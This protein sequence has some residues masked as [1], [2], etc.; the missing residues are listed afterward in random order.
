MGSHRLGL[1]PDS[2]IQL[3]NFVF[4]LTG[5]RKY[6]AKCFSNARMQERINI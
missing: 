5:N 1:V 4:K 3:F 2:D 6:D